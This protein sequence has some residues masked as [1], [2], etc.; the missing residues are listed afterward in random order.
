MKQT[1][2]AATGRVIGLDVARGLAVIGMFVA[3]VSAGSDNPVV[4]R[5]ISAADGRSSILF[6]TLAGLS[7]AILSG[8]MW[9]YSGPDMLAAKTRIL[10]RA[11]CLVVISGIL[12]MMNEMVALILI[13]YAVWFVLAIPFL[14]WRPRNLFI[15]AGCFWLFGPLMYTYGMTV[16]EKLGLVMYGG[17]S[18]FI[19]TILLTGVYPGV[20]YMGYVLAGL[21]IGRLD[22]SAKKIQATLVLVGS[23]LALI[24]YSASDLFLALIPTSTGYDPGS[25]ADPW[26]ESGGFGWD[27]SLSWPDPF[28]VLGMSPH[29]NTL[30]E[31]FGSGGVALGVIGLC[32]LG[33]RILGLV[34]FPLAAVGS[35]SLTAYSAHVIAIWNSETLAMRETNTGL[36]WLVLV[37]MVAC[38][39]WRLTIGRGPLEWILYRLS[40][41][42]ARSVL[43][44]AQFVPQVAPT[45]SQ[46]IIAGPSPSHDAAWQVSQSPT[47]EVPAGEASDR[48]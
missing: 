41:R 48:A 39:I 33:G 30:F 13:Y 34:A 38:T 2:S 27:S 26:S 24:F 17:E 25:V 12:S 23:S 32:L 28:N 22:L 44:E 29:S 20:V 5:L 15:A 4:S 16:L 14:R 43:R 10:T 35:M 40:H 21:G 42:A 31:A 9:P 7:L 37:T 46:P 6:A 8:R 1:L 11:A 3:H 18:N 47:G 45:V 36:G 19:V